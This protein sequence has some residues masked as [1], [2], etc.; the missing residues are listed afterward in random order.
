MIPQHLSMIQMAPVLPYQLD[1]AQKQMASSQH[2]NKTHQTL[3]D[4]SYNSVWG[5]DK[6]HGQPVK[7]IGCHCANVLPSSYRKS[8]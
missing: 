4:V 5:W 1:T 6:V 8:F 2:V 3:P 7:A